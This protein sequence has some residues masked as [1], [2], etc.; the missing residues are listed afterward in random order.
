MFLLPFLVKKIQKDNIYADLLSWFAECGSRNRSPSGTV[1]ASLYS[2]CRRR[3]AN[4]ECTTH[5]L[6]PLS[7]A[8]LTAANGHQLAVIATQNHSQ[9][10]GKFVSRQLY[11]IIN[12]A[13]TK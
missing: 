4:D 2:K 12:M 6:A 8:W 7:D 3:Q 1:I 11:V 9:Q 13:E 10:Q 5:T